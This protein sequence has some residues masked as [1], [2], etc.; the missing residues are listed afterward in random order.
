MTKTRKRIVSFFLVL[1]LVMSMVPAAFA[2]EIETEPE[3]TEETT[4]LPP[5]KRRPPPNRRKQNLPICQCRQ[6]K[7][8]EQRNRLMLRGSLLGVFP[9]WTG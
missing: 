7:Q 6:L 5:E 9:S 8:E 2:A 3:Q 4:T 1:A